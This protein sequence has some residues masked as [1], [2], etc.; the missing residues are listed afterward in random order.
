MVSLAEVWRSLGVT[1]DAVIGHSQGEIAAACAAGALTLEDG[2][3]I[4]ALR[5]RMLATT[6]QDGGMAG[7]VAPEDRVRELLEP[8][9]S[10]VAIAAI[11]GP[12]STSV[13]GEATAV[14]E[15]VA[16]CA[17]QGVRARWIPASVPGHSP[18]MDRFED[19][20]RDELGHIAPVA[21]PVEFYSTVTGGPMDTAELDAAYWF[22]NMRE[23]VQ[24]E[25]A[26]KR[27]LEARYGA[28][29]E[30]SPHPLLTINIQVMLDTTPGADGVVV[31][32]LRRGD[33][34]SARLYRSVAEAFVAGVE[35]A[36]ESAFPGRDGRWVELPTY[37]FQRQRY[38]LDTPD[39]STTRSTSDHPLLDAVIDLPDDGERGGVVGS[40]RLSLN[41]HP[42]LADHMVHGAVLAPETA[43]V[44]M[45]VWAAH[46]AGCDVV[47]E[48]TLET[49]LLLSRTA[50]REIRV[51][52]DDKRVIGVHSRV[53][54]EAEWTRNAVGVLGVDTAGTRR[55]ADL[56]AWPPAG[57]V[58][59]PLEEAGLSVLGLDDGPLRRGVKEVW[60]RDDVLFAEVGLPALDGT[61]PGGFRI[62]PAL[63]Q[64]ALLPIGLGPFVDDSRPEGWLPYRWTGIRLNSATV[65]ALRVRIAPAGR[66]R[67][68]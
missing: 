67:C 6:A 14:R 7:I 35:V 16:A 17:S 51:V 66:T 27:L 33:G 32:S 52:V 43:L 9:E 11:N 15:L 5:S 29:V 60:R 47:D 45:A 55:E 25:A 34:G 46:R 12:Y 36:W 38:W 31:G 41:R 19:R 59:V 68:R 18:L 1:P 44:E 23:P 49:P 20:L 62:H 54:G 3:K 28:F 48:L 42:W 64:A 4:V 26:M 2:A 58:E 56:T 37:A 65:T 40:G 50:D 57:A 61:G 8:W 39:E 22:R 13:S 21:S 24:F 63:F 10:R 53:E 30:A